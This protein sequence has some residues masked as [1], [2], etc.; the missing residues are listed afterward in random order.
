MSQ[1]TPHEVAESIGAAYWSVDEGRWETIAPALPDHVVDLLAPP[2]LVGAAPCGMDVVA[3]LPAPIA[4]PT[5]DPTALDRLDMLVPAARDP[6]VVAI[7]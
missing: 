4:P 7:A 6:R 3:A 2:I 5:G 1:H